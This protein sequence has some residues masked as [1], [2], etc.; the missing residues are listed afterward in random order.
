MKRGWLVAA[1]V[2][3][4]M[5]AAGGFELGRLSKQSP[6]RAAASPRIAPTVT[7]TVTPAVTPT[8][9][10]GDSGTESPTTETG[11]SVAA[12]FNRLCGGVMYTQCLTQARAAIKNDQALTR[13]NC[14]AGAVQACPRQFGDPLVQGCFPASDAQGPAWGPD[15]W[16]TLVNNLLTGA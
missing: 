12:T 16:C 4:V 15:G 3:I 6:V 2:L 11:L 7:V 5:A 13:Q 8:V 9:S 1:V 14:A 10:P